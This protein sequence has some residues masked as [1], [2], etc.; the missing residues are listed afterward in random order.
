[1]ILMS[2]ACSRHVGLTPAQK[3]ALPGEHIVVIGD[4][5]TMGPDDN[6]EDPD[7]WPAL[8][9]SRLR[10]QKY[11]VQDTVAG[12]GGAGYVQPG[13][14]GGVFGDK[15]SAVQP[16][17]DVVVIFGS[18]NDLGA[19]PA[20]ER[21]AVRTALSRVRAVAPH[22]HLVVIGPVW[23]RRNDVPAQLLAVRDAIRDEAVGAG[24]TFTDP[25]SQGW[26]WEDPGLIGPDWLH[27]NRS[28]QRYLAEKILPLI[29]AE[30]PP[31]GRA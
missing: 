15:V 16:N 14:R 6:P 27:P 28:G 23:P 4:S 3:A 25:L 31:P 9:L 2:V 18:A 17:T 13:Y 5:Y 12:E 22:T 26:L 7:A 11:V 24:A 10:A 8:A 19:D 20:Q 30:L 29:Q 21:A 1:M